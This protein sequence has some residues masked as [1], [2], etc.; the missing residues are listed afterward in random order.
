MIPNRAKC[1]EY[2]KFEFY[3][4]EGR[5][6]FSFIMGTSFR[7]LYCTACNFWLTHFMSLHTGL[8][9]YS[10]KTTENQRFSDIFRGY[11]KRP[12]AWNRLIICLFSVSMMLS[13]DVIQNYLVSLEKISQLGNV[14][15]VLSSFL[16]S[17]TKVEK[18]SLK[19]LQPLRK[20]RGRK[21]Y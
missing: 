3:K 10:Q 8:F 19:E 11:R 15:S 18:G 16:T 12:V 7:Q 4:S 21:F 6:F 20:N 1:F 13:T 5:E 14:D 2:N 9:L 17:E